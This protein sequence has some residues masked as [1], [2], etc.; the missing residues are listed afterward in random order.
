[1]HQII[2]IIIIIVVLLFIVACNNNY[3]SVPNEAGLGASDVSVL[4]LT[5]VDVPRGLSRA[6]I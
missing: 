5:P 1:M 6:F 4:G 2:I 3:I